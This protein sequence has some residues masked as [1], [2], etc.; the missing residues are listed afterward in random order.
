MLNGDALAVFVAEALLAFVEG[1]LTF[2]YSLYGEEWFR[3]RSGRPVE[4]PPLQLAAVY[5]ILTLYGHHEDLAAKKWISENIKA[6]PKT[7]RAALA[8]EPLAP[9]LDLIDLLH[10]AGKDYRAIVGT[11]KTVEAAYEAL[12]GKIGT[13]VNSPHFLLAALHAPNLF[14]SPSQP[15]E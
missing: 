15:M 4:H 13:R 8:S 12:Y 6:N 9:S 5:L 14:R 1:E 11:V 2:E 10:L 7:V 3:R